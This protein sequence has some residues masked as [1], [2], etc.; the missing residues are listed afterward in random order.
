MSIGRSLGDYIWAFSK[1]CLNEETREQ[2]RKCLI[3]YLGVTVAGQ[4][5][6][7]QATKTY[8]DAVSSEKG[9]IPVLGSGLQT[10][11]LHAAYLN[12]FNAHYLE[13]DDG[14]RFAMLH[15][16][17]PVI[18][19]LIPLA[20]S[21]ASSWD[22]FYRS[23]IS[24]YELTI[25]L[26][27]RLQPDLKLKGFH[28]TGVCGS[29]GAAAAASLLS[30]ADAEQLMTAISLAATSAA[31][32]LEV[33]ADDS[34]IKPH[35]VANA[36]STGLQAGLAGLAGYLPPEDILG[37]SRGLIKVLTGQ[38]IH[39]D[40]DLSSQGKAEI[41]GVYFKPYA[42]CRHSH[43]AIEA[44]LYLRD[45][46]DSLDQIEAIDVYSYKLAIQG[47]D[48][49]E[50]SSVASAKMSTPFG[51]VSALMTGFLNERSFEGMDQ[52]SPLM[53]RLLSLVSIHEDQDYTDKSP[54]IRAS[55]LEIRLSNGQILSKEVLYPKGEPENPMSGIELE[56][57]MLGLFEYARHG[58][59]NVIMASNDPKGLPAD[60]FILCN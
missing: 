45:Q 23:L 19:A 22:E 36:A 44:A 13:L 51:L 30:G 5:A 14:H 12:A 16:G 29:I 25:S 38:R 43:P 3:D 41:M 8:L 57:K 7:E 18:S 49:R 35:N 56:E 58:G 31:G 24:G 39:D 33:T 59:E 10:T 53:Q 2:A 48:H 9:N 4:S 46:I 34:Q 6:N 28:G 11:A 32:L 54:Q 15:P 60:L 17:A 40:W 55:R 26:A 52:A 37:G 20:I 42:A 27:R 1:E 47:H 21:K 50:V